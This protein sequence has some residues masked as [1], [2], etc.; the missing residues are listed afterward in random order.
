MK[1]LIS[2]GV[3]SPLK[4]VSQDIVANIIFLELSSFNPMTF[5][6]LI[7]LSLSWVLPLTYQVNRRIHR[8]RKE[9]EVFIRFL[10]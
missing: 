5:V 4:W 2:T 3:L 9:E 8:T 1:V 6:Y 7:A 10:A